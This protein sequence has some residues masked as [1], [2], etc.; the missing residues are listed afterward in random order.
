MD[1]SG[2]S[3]F[4][5][6]PDATKDVLRQRADTLSREQ[7]DESVERRTEVLAFSVGDEWYAVRIGD[8][9]EILSDYHI[10]WLPSLP[11][12]ILGVVNIRGEVTSVT[13][14]RRILGMSDAGESE[15]PMI[16]VGDEACKTA[17]VVDEI[18]DIVEIPEGGIEPPLSVIDRRHV[19]YVEGSVSAGDR[20]IALVDLEKILEPIGD[21][22]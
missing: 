1:S 20:L 16:V 19:E 10:T 11:E 22:D 6:L 17:L 21:E 9:K 14:F 15:A 4:G 2:R 3:G 13:D 12:H 8:V 7:V 5:S 18:G